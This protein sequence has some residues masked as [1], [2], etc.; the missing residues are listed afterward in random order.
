MSAIHIAA[1]RES[2]VA[3][4][5]VAMTPETAKKF[6]A[7]GASVSVETGAGHGASIADAAYAEAGAAVADR[8]TV[9][10]AANVVLAVQ[11]PSPPRSRVS[12]PAPGWSAISIPLR[13]AAGS[14]LMP[15]LA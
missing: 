4:R 1:L 6:I 12:A 8:E 14:R 5:R 3:E 2:A 13:I 11:G 9:L 7:L 15:S 10:R